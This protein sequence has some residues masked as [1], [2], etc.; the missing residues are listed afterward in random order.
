[1]SARDSNGSDHDQGFVET[2]PARKMR[3]VSS[4][5]R[6]ALLLGE[7]GVLA[8]WSKEVFS[9]SDRE[10]RDINLRMPPSGD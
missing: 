4:E 3:T 2:F 9:V 5:V 6:S 1:M 10:L 8:V 7:D